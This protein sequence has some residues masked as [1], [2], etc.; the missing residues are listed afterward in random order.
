MTIMYLFKRIIVLLIISLAF[1]LTNYAQG[2][3]FIYIQS[4]RKQPFYV[5]LNNKTNSSTPEGYIILPQIL[6]GKHLITIGFPKNAFPEQNFLL[7]I[8]EDK[9]YSFKR[10]PKNVWQLFDLNNFVTINPVTNLDSAIAETKKV[11]IPPTP[12]KDTVVTQKELPKPIE[13]AKPTV[14]IAEQ[15]AVKADTVKPVAFVVQKVGTITIAKPA[16]IGEKPALVETPKPVLVEEHKT[17]I[18]NPAIKRAELNITAFVDSNSK[19][20]DTIVVIHKRDTIV[21]TT[22]VAVNN[23]D[24]FVPKEVVIKPSTIKL[25]LE[26]Q[27]AT[28]IDKVFIDSTEN[29]VDTISVYIPLPAVPK[30]IKTAAGTTISSPVQNKTLLTDDEFK[31]LRL[32]MASAAADEDMTAVALKVAANKLLEVKQIKNLSTLYLNDDNKLNFFKAIKGNVQDV[33]NFPS[34]VGE[35][36]ETK[37]IAGFK[38]L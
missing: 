37:N 2:K 36:S 32:S 25:I 14:V 3:N 17:E 15:K 29:G 21:P 23:T 22:P 11:Y 31:Q 19:K 28:G 5:I 9:G 7:E 34:L 27:Q 10:T 24:I 33:A 12:A 13:V 4:D 38:G 8:N 20:S 30:T 18:T 35:L 1:P 16:I 26:K 6:Q